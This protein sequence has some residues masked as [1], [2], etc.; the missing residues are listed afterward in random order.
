VF[1]NEN[2]EKLADDQIIPGD[3]PKSEIDLAGIS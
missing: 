3:F 1:G 2:F